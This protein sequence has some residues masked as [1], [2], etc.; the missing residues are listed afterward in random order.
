MK[1]RGNIVDNF[2]Q[3][4]NKPTGD[5]ELERFSK[6]EN[7]IRGKMSDS[8]FYAPKGEGQVDYGDIKTTALLSKDSKIYDGDSSFEYAIDNNLMYKKYPQ[9]KKTTGLDT[10]QEVSD[11]YDD[12]IPES[13]GANEE[14]RK[15][16]NLFYSSFQQ[17][18]EKELRNKGYDGARWSREDDL[19]PLQYQIW[20]SD[21][22]KLT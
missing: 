14:Y 11:A 7:N 12:G 21:K 1:N 4:A 20:N 3:F 10:L 16:P 9:V 22:I 18:A 8:T 5:I 19:N 6:E 17:V 2:E 15:N 13:S